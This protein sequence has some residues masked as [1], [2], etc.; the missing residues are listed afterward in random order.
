M[1]TYFK[2]IYTLLGKIE[3]ASEAKFKFNIPVK[4]AA[5]V[6]IEVTPQQG[7]VESY[8]EGEISNGLKEYI[9][10]YGNKNLNDASKELKDE[11]SKITSTI[12]QA[13][14]KVLHNI[15]YWLRY[16]SLSERLFSIKVIHCS[17]D[18]SKWGQFPFL[19]KCTIDTDYIL[20]LEEYRS[21]VIQDYIQRGIEPFVALRHL[22]RAKEEIIPRYKWIDATI[23][24]ELAI[25]EFFLSLKPDLEPLLLELPSPPLHKLYGQILE[26]YTGQPSPYVSKL[27]KGA[28]RRNRLLHRPQEGDITEEEANEYIHD[29]ESAIYHLLTLLYPKEEFICACYR[30]RGKPTTKKNTE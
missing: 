24:S 30:T 3:C 15:K 20:P 27:A 9:S 5:D 19:I 11:A 26:A 28:E 21:K 10:L 8:W 14:R 18:K 7:L 16:H 6:I 29:V 13:V 22:H 23:A 12:N 17:I 2:G 25:K 4:D 1:N